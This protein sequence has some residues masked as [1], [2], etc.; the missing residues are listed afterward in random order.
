MKSDDF[1]KFDVLCEG[2]DHAHEKLLVICDSRG[3]SSSWKTE[4]EKSVMLVA[5]S[6]F[7]LEL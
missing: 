6:W 2:K 5:D 7:F 3:V 4:L 1:K